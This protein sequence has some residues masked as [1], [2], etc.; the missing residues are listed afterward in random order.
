ME[1]ALLQG[2]V[3]VTG[4]KHIRETEAMAQSDAGLG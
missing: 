2:V 1:R 4:N 3:T